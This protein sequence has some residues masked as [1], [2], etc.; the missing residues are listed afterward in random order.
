MKKKILINGPFPP[1]FSYGGPTKSIKNLY[2]ALSTKFN[3]TIISPNTQL[4]SKIII[5]TPDA[6]EDIIYTSNQ[7]SEI[8]KKFNKSN[9]IWLNSFFEFKTTFILYLNIFCKKKL[10]ISPRGQLSIEAI[11]TSNFFLKNF[12]IKLINPLQSQIVFHSTS[13]EETNDIKIFFPKS[14]IV[15]I[16]N[17][18]NQ[19][20]YEN[21]STRK[22]FLFYS[23]IHKKKGLDKILKYLDEH[24]LDIDLD[25]YGFIEDKKYWSY[26]ESFIKRM[27]NIRYMGEISDG[28]IEKLRGKYMFYIFPTL[29]EN[30][31]HVIIE[32]ISEGIIPILSRGTTPFDSLTSEFINLNFELNSSNDFINS[33]QKSLSLNIEQI[34]ILRKSLK[35]LYSKIKTKESVYRKDYVNFIN[36]F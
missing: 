8:L 6:Q 14:K 11:K 21:T 34:S 4:N 29:N 22:N 33:I 31:G 26:C 5:N 23:R 16:P 17:I 1:L 20:Y 36:Q 28:N 3:C 18:S 13:I 2:E 7:I 35:Q 12:F 9:I 10:I 25:I 24:S 15:E 32:L 19:E 27:K 30:F